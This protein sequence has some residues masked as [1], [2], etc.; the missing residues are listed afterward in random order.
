M[1]GHDTLVDRTHA[2]TDNILIRIDSKQK[3]I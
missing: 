2:G 3:S 1:K